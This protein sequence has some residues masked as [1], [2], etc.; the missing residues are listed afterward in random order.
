MKSKKNW[1]EPI[2]VT[3]RILT[4]IRDEG[5]PDCNLGFYDT[6]DLL[7]TKKNVP[8]ARKWQPVLFW[9]RNGY[10]KGLLRF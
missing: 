4:G 2:F 8:D 5:T 9:S 3:E 6:F 1:T 7:I 10:P